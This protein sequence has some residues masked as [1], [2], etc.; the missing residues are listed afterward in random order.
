MIKHYIN[1]YKV[2]KKTHLDIYICNLTH[3]NWKSIIM[4]PC[5]NQYFWG[6]VRR[7]ARALVRALACLGPG[8]TRRLRPGFHNYRF[9]HRPKIVDFAI[10]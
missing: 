6:R 5:G 1:L 10:S 2:D 3:P 8:P 7:R 4:G 9:L